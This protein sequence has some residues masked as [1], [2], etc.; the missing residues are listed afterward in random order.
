[1]TYLYQVTILL[2][3]IKYVYIV[4]YDNSYVYGENMYE[5][6]EAS[7]H[8]VVQRKILHTNDFNK[9][10]IGDDMVNVMIVSD[11]ILDY[12]TIVTQAR[13]ILSNCVN[14][15]TIQ[16]SKRAKMSEAL[17]NLNGCMRRYL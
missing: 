6:E 11:D 7:P 10:F 16:K 8:F 3:G 5:F 1:M 4:R 2:T 9:A 17:R 13:L 15:G 12:N 14:D